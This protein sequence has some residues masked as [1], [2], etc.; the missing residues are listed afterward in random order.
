VGS[1]G[2]VS[3]SA[4]F[5]G[6]YNDMKLDRISIATSE[7]LLESKLDPFKAEKITEED[8]ALIR[9]IQDDIFVHFKTHVEECRKGKLNE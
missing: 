5:K 6:L 3:L 4:K 2:V 8:K 1:I 7:E 9:G